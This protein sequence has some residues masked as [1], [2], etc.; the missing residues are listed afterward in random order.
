[1]EGN[2]NPKNITM[3]SDKMV[4][5]QFV[6]NDT[7]DPVV[8]II[9]PKKNLLYVFNIP[10]R[11]LF[12]KNTEIVGFIVIKAEATD[13]Q[14]IN[15]VEFYI[16]NELR[17]K[18]VAKPY[19][20]IWI[21]KLKEKGKMHTIKVIAYDEANNSNMAIIEVKA[22]RIIRFFHNHPQL[23]RLGSLLLFSN[24][25]RSKSSAVEP[26]VPYEPNSPIAY[27]EAPLTGSV[28]IEIEFDGSKSYD[29]NG[30]EISFE[31]DFGDG[32]NEVGKL[33]YH[34]YELP[35][36][37][38]I[39]LTVSDEE[40]NAGT[41]SKIISIYDS[42]TEKQVAKSGIINS[43][44]GNFIWYGLGAIAGLILLVGTVFFI[45]RFKK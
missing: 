38:N 1:L 15:R 41:I 44:M 25:L 32:T 30:D 33:T 34:T 13:D 26:Q 19:N 9:K 16:D 8:K 18:D 37:Y 43:N 21:P 29:P 5:A 12:F 24:L 10:R 2:E 42:E 22:G 4:T 17:S 7:E 39:T 36:E 27:I 20:Y 45:F 23:S 14:G 3:N 35:G 40:G 28:G 11:I 31:W 6:K